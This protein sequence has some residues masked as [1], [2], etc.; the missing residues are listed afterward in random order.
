[1]PYVPPSFRTVIEKPIK[2]DLTSEKDFP[3]LGLSVASKKVEGNLFAAKAQEW[4]EQRR[5]ADYKKKLEEERIEEERI[6][7]ERE[8]E[9]YSIMFPDR[10]KKVVTVEKKEDVKEEVVSEWTVVRKAPRRE[11]KSKIDFSS[12]PE[13]E[14]YSDDS[15]GYLSH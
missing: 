14:V 1:M 6:K 13:N 10:K 2:I 15:E 9:E 12:N 11:P 8:A 4:E 3:T 7:Q 5:E